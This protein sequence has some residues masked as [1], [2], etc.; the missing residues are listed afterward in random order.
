[1]GCKVG[2]VFSEFYVP[3]PLKAVPYYAFPWP[4]KGYKAVDAFVIAKSWYN[5]ALAFFC[6]APLNFWKKLNPFLIL[7][8]NSY[9]FFKSAGAIRL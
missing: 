6:P 4:E 8:G 5:K 7:K 3:S 1:M 9:T 2:K